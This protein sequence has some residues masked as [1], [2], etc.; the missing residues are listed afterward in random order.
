[1]QAS[2]AQR[3]AVAAQVMFY[4]KEEMVGHVSRHQQHTNSTVA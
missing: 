2:A 4:T 1:M 3:C